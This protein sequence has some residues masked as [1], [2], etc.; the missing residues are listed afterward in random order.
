MWPLEEDALVA[1]GI[2]MS[3]VPQ[4][5][6]EASSDG[7]NGRGK[8]V[9][10]FIG[11]HALLPCLNQVRDFFHHPTEESLATF[12]HMHTSAHPSIFMKPKTIVT[13]SGEEITILS[14]EEF[15]ASSS[16]RLIPR[17]RW[18]VLVG[19]NLRVL[20]FMWMW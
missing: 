4:N 15:V 2:S 18:K 10:L 13:P 8:L 14:S 7:Y 6:R 20:V 16:K 5:P 3:R 12:A 9:P 17:S 1:V 11:F 19:T